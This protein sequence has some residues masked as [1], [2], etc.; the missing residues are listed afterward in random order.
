MNV[1]CVHYCN[2]FFF[3]ADVVVDAGDFLIKF[4]KIWSNVDWDFFC[5]KKGKNFW[6]K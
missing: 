1:V 5:E 2:G 6:E 4:W 3:A